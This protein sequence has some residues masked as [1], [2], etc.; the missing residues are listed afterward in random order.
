MH[1]LVLARMGLHNDAL[2]CELDGWSH[3]EWVERARADEGVRVRYAAAGVA[4][5]R[6]EKEIEAM[7][8]WVFLSMRRR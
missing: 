8:A 7:A 1:A 5:E 4:P 3:D 2:V 6:L